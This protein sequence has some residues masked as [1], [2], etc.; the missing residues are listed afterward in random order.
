MFN[1]LD[2]MGKVVD[3]ESGKKAEEE[4]PKLGASHLATMLRKRQQMTA[5]IE[6][7]KQK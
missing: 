3:M 4:K 2:E 1:L 6:A 7:A 5:K